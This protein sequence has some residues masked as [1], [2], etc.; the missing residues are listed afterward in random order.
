MSDF[1]Y[2]NKRMTTGFLTD[3]IKKIYHEDYPKVQEF[4]GN[5]GSIAISENLYNG[6]QPYE[7]ERY[8]FA[9]IGGPVLFFQDN[10]FLKMNDSNIGTKAIFDRWK[11][12]NI[13]WDEDLSGPFAIIIIN[14]VSSKVSFVTDLMSFIPIYIYQDISNF[15]LS[16]HVDVLAEASNQNEDFDIISCADYVLNGIITYPYTLYKKI[17]QVRPGTIHYISQESNQLESKSYWLPQEKDEYSSISEAATDLKQGMLNFTNRV[18][19]EVSKIAQFISGGED[20]RVLSALLNEYPRSAYVFLDQMN[21]EGRMAKEAAQI[22]NA[23]F[24]IATR[25]KTHYIDILPDCSDLLGSGSQYHHAHTFDFH[26]R[27]KLDQYYA[28]FGGL[29]SDALLKGARIKKL[30]IS[31]KLPLIGDIKDNSYSPENYEENPIFTKSIL[32]EVS[33][34]R[35]AHLNELKIYRPD[36]AEE[37]FELWPSS[38][39][40]NIPNIHANRRLF[41]SYEPLWQMI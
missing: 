36:S 25:S 24:N 13:N 7:T 30:R 8:I 22:Y 1:L 32:K 3:K 39:N 37:W 5:W 26:K 29:F 27:C 21:R 28:V 11:A 34:R 9:V 14:K 6:F 38:M 31:N 2:T 23:N 17:N 18:T 33:N 12:N 16:T 20:S 19:S 10:Y 40:M 15:M 35:R 4:H 41:R